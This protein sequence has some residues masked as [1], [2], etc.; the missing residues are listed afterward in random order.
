MKK[1]FKICLTMFICAIFVFPG[2]NVN[3]RQNT[4]LRAEPIEHDIKKINTGLGWAQYQVTGKIVAYNLEGKDPRTLSYSYKIRVNCNSSG[5]ISSFSTSNEKVT[6][7]MP[8]YNAYGKL[9]FIGTRN[10]TKLTLTER[11]QICYTQIGSGEQLSHFVEN[12]FI[13]NGSGPYR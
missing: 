5:N 7:S 12:T 8:E 6:G 11:V 9:V 3:A 4:V 1:I 2:L 10:G 13:I